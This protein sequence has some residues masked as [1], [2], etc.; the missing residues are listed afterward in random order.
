MH[1][2][3]LLWASLSGSN[4]PRPTSLIISR[5]LSI[6][7]NLVVG[8]G[9]EFQPAEDPSGLRLRCL[10]KI[11]RQTGFLGYLPDICSKSIGTGEVLVWLRLTPAG[12]RIR[13]YH[14]DE[15][16]PYFRPDSD[17]L[18]A[19]IIKYSVQTDK[20]PKYY[21]VLVDS[22]GYYTTEDQSYQGFI[23]LSPNE[24]GNWGDIDQDKFTFYPHPVP[25]LP[26][27]LIR[28]RPTGPGAR[29][30]HDFIGL[31]EEITDNFKVYKAVSRNVRKFAR[32]TILTNI[33]QDQ[34]MKKTGDGP[35][36]MQSPSWKAGFRSVHP[37]QQ[38]E[39]TEI[40]EYIGVDG[41]PGETFVQPIDW[42]PINSDQ[43]Q[44]LSD[45]SEAIYDALSSNSKIGGNT[46]YE[47]RAM[48][49]VPLA[50]A[51]RKSRLIFDEAICPM[52]SDCLAYE[53]YLLKCPDAADRSVVWRRIELVEPSTRDQLDVSILTRNLSEQGVG[54]SE[55]LKLQF[56]GRTEED[57]KR[58]TGGAGGIPYRKIDKTVPAIQQLLDLAGTV[59]DPA[60][61]LRV[62]D[63][64]SSLV[65]SLEESLNYGRATAPDYSDLGTPYPSV[66][67]D[68]PEP[69]SL[70]GSSSGLANSGITSPGDGPA[71]GRNNPVRD[72]FRAI[73]R[74]SGR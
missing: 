23:S 73:W 8:Q 1:F 29:S 72:F 14:F 62:Y 34:L 54:D 21:R 42:N 46:A 11:V 17:D 35:N 67:I 38:A 3:D 13:Y 4:E 70:G 22:S 61:Q 60:V 27:Y 24:V 12:Y 47:T 20:G 71:T 2:K 65:Y 51:N 48:I 57:I 30:T 69:Q 32:Q 40:A 53:C 58:I 63:L 59:V 36:V 49:A 16:V 45:W 15:F 7:S 33:P 56:P 10:Q 74:G 39:E 28:N 25:F 37:V 66:N 6:L 52:L 9:I 5:H 44:Y 43:T 55:L 50:S 64:A 18:M 41:L 26:I 31:E 68:S 19:A